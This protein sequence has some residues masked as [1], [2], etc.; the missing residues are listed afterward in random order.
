[1]TGNFN[2][3]YGKEF[4]PKAKDQL[5]TLSDRLMETTTTISLWALRRWKERAQ[6][7][8]ADNEY[9]EGFICIGIPR[10]SLSSK[11][12]RH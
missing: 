2:D 1:M 3:Y 12:V 5:N 6:T 4:H 10:V 8:G 9:S 11:T 7:L